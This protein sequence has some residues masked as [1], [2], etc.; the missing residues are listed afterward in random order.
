MQKQMIE[1]M[2]K[3]TAVAMESARKIGEL[4]QRNFDKLFQQQADL[5]AF[6]M[7]AGARGLE[8]MTKAK[9]YQD[10]LAGQTALMRE[11]GERGIN[12]V[13]ESIDLAKEVSTE[14]GTLAQE[15]FSIAKQQMEE[16]SSLK[17]AA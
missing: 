2:E 15:G 9:G 4:N 3:N 8:L 5:A 11:C 16:V 6:F 12:A 7:D 17:V 10:L 1:M 13:R 14:Y